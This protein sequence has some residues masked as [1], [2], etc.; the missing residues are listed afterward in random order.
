M[1]FLSCSNSNLNNQIDFRALNDSLTIANKKLTSQND[2]LYVALQTKML[3]EEKVQLATHWYPRAMQFQYDSHEIYKYLEDYVFKLQTSPNS[4]N[5]DSLYKKLN[6]YKELI[7]R[8]DPEMHQHI[9][10]K[11]N[12]ITN[13]FDSVRHTDTENIGIHLSSKSGEEQFFILQLTRNRIETIENA[14]LL[15]CNLK[16]DNL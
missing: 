15:F 9:R 11:A 10:Q 7:F 12:I 8:I 13:Y 16:V 4:N 3:D 5:G 6:L 1:P 2:S 14:I